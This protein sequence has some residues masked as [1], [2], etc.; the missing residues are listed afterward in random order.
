MKFMTKALA[1]LITIS[2]LLMNPMTSEF[3]ARADQPVHCLRQDI[4]GDWTFH[5]G[6]DQELVNLFEVGGLCTHRRPNG[7]QVINR[8]FKFS[9]A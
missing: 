4:Y 3:G 2:M 7:V 9:F 5:V 1:R 8:D 6:K